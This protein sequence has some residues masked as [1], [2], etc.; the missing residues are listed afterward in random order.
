MRSFSDAERYTASALAREDLYFFSRWMFLS[1]KGFQWRRARHHQL[2]CDALMRVFTG[3]CR[4]LIINIPPR[5]S[6]AI[7]CDTPMWTPA[8][9]VRAGDIAVGDRLL[10][11]DGQWTTV[12]GVHPQGVKPAFDVRFTDGASLVA[13]G[14]HRWAVR[15][16]DKVVGRD[17]MAPWRVKTT[18]ELRGDL[19]EAD[20]RRKWRIP[21]LRDTNDADADLPLDPYLLGCWLGDGTTRGASITTMDQEIVSA[22]AAF[23]PKPYAHQNGGRATIYGLRRRFSTL[24]RSLGVFGNKHIPQAY[25]HAS[26]R[27]RLALL[28]GLCDTDGWVAAA[29][30]QQGICFSNQRLSDDVRALICSLGGTWR[31]FTDLPARGR[32]SHKTFFLM[33]AGDVAF[34]LPRKVERINPRAERNTP[35]R[36]VASIEPVASREMVCFTVDAADHLFCAGR[37][38]VVTHNTELAVVNFIAWAMGKVPDAEFIHASYSAT[39]ATNN[40]TQIRALV[41]HEAY[42][43]IFPGLGLASDAQ[44]HWKTTAGGVMYATG[45]GGTITG[46]GAGKH[47]DGFGGCFPVG[48]R[49]WTESGLMPIDRI[50]RQRLGVRV[51][52]YDYAGRMVLRPVIGWHE[53]PPNAIVRVEFDDGAAVECTPDHRF[54]TQNRGWVRADSLREDDRL[55]CVRGG[56]ESLDHVRVDA[57]GG[58][59]WLDA[60]AILPAGP[61]GPVRQGQIC[62]GAGQDRSGVGGDSALS[63]YVEPA[64]NGCPGIAAPDLVDHSCGY[65]MAP[66]Q[67]GGL[68]SGAVVDG[69]RLIISEQGARMGFGLAEGAVGLAISDVRG[70][71]VIPEVGESVVLGVAVGVADVCPIRAWSDESE[72]DQRMH[73]GEFDDGAARQADSQVPAGFLG[74]AQD[75]PGLFPDLPGAAFGDQ[76]ILAADTSSIADRVGAFVSGYRRPVLVRY[77]RHDESTFCLTVKEHHNFTVEHGLVV[78]NCIIIDDPHKAD[79]ARSDVVRQGVLDWFQTTLESRKNS[80][81]TPIIVIMQRLHED[82]LAGWLLRGGNGERWEHLCLPVWNEDGTPLWP[83]KHDAEE[84][85]RMEAAAPYVFAGQY[86]QRPAPPDGGVFKPDQLTV[87]DAVPTGVRWV[88]GWD[89]GSTTD[90]DPTAG[91]KLGLL[92][93]GRYIIGD[94]VWMQAG[95]DERDAALRNTAARDG[96]PVRIS[97]PQD[98]G[99]AGKTQVLYLTRQLA[100]Y[101]VRSSPESGDKITRAEPFASQVNVGNV[102][103]L[104]APWNDALVSEMRLFPN[105]AHDD[106][107]DSLSRAFAE[108]ESGPRIAPVAPGGDTRVSPWRG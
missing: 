16:R 11:S 48:T 107:I 26:H 97:I 33:P 30:G 58:G 41:Q 106:R 93:D 20:G 19:H 88:R 40:S 22:F 87:V 24:L 73:A 71:A 36:F 53:N 108:L 27:Q 91:G 29:T 80:P 35:R 76:S 14:D 21:V 65:T 38:F 94:M 95:P 86:L 6:K 62:L 64:G 28:Q 104:R 37:D 69:Q 82:D 17:W 8:G 78:K 79:E 81:D 47:R 74:G 61:I 70:P 51:W 75:L 2:I 84:L 54:W 50:V 52:S 66:S 55:P 9:W 72:K 102:L 92:P 99:Q 10:G 77:V 23:D 67:H 57:D 43:A 13:C 59:G 56:V 3:E 34:R 25:M 45:T 39:L 96:K 15:L 46:F 100:G 7:D 103:M 1:R 31:G 42:R 98:P 5:Y 83:E 101:T 12:V 18:D 60:S 89:F 68:H 105:G 90:G 85:Q 49:V 32:P 4:R 44:H 63:G